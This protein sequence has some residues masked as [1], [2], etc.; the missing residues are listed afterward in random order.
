MFT[1]LDKDVF[2]RQM[3]VYAYEPLQIKL[4]N[5]K[6]TTLNNN[7]SVLVYSQNLKIK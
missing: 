1:S 4:L 7:K 2:Q 6:H 3:Y 5:R